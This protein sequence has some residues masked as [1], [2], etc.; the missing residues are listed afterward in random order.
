MN[1]SGSPATASALDVLRWSVVSAR[2]TPWVS[3]AD[4]LD[5]KFALPL[6]V[7]DTWWLPALRLV[8]VSVA[9]SPVSGTAV[10]N[11]CPSTLNWTPPAERGRRPERRQR[12][13]R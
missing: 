7:A 8:I 11:G 13:W 6:Y 2:L 9:V 3:S 12:P 1:V 4:V 5:A 10:P